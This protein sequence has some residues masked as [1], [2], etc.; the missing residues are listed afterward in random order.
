MTN[1]RWHA[2]CKR[3]AYVNVA[4]ARGQGLVSSGTN[5]RFPSRNPPF[6]PACPDRLGQRPRSDAESVELAGELNDL[7]FQIALLRL[8][9]H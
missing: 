2:G 6:G 4:L 5:A 3:S 7:G 8:N 9:E 1:S